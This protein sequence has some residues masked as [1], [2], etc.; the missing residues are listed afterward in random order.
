[1]CTMCMSDAYRS[2][3]RALYPLKLKL[4]MFLS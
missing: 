4:W 2:Q 1:M 3:K